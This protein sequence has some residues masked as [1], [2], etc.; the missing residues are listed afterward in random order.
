MR[1]EI[2]R[3]ALLV[4][5]RAVTDLQGSYQVVV[6]GADN[7]AEI[8]PVKAGRRVEQRWIIEDGLK[9]GE[10]IVVEGTQKARAGIV[11][12][13][14]PWNP[15]SAPVPKTQIPSSTTPAPAAPNR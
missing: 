11:V 4:P 9:P 2:R 6:V 1:A 8:R 13:P 3:G 7:K 10:H 15:P 5:Q 14:K 12:N